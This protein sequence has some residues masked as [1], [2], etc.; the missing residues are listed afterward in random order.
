MKKMTKFFTGFILAAVFSSSTVFAIPGLKAIDILNKA[1][2]ALNTAEKADDTITKFSRMTE[3]I[4][5]ENAY[6]VGRS[7]A[8]SIFHIYP[9]Y[10]NTNATAYLNRICRAIAMNSPV[11]VI[12][13]QYC[14]GII[15]TNE[16]NAL[17]TAS[18]MILISKGLLSSVES[19]DELAA[20]IAHELAH[21][22]L[23]HA[24]GVIKSSR[25]NDFIQSTTVLAVDVTNKYS[26]LS[27]DDKKLFNEF[28]GVNTYLVD[29]ITTKGYPKDQE[30]KA[31]AEALN[32]LLSAGYDPNAMTSM[33]KKLDASYKARSDAKEGGWTKT[34][35]KPA[36][37]LKK[38]EALCK[39]MAYKGADP[40]V[41]AARFKANMG[42]FI[43]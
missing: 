24:V 30:F 34:H 8:A 3:P 10:K 13:K 26:K 27:E 23:E 4:T 42:A 6:Y 15:D 14:V 33:L 31:D 35:P 1:Q 41:R 36:D 12:Y 18:G 38:V 19:E 22:Q 11:P 7:T 25:V 20:V 43:K 16:V 40:S 28:A 17:S 21:V 9:M 5:A 2:N 29:T 39:K 32:L 37:R